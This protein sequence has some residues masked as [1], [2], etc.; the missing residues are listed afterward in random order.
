MDEEEYYERFDT[1]AGDPAELF[2]H[3]ERR[4]E[5]GWTY[6]A[7]SDS[8][9]GVERG[10]VILPEPGV[11]VRGYPS[12]PR[13]L[14]LETGIPSFFDDETTVAVEEKLNGFNVRIVDAGE[15]LAFTRSGYLCPYTTARAR[16]LLDPAEFFADHPEAM[17]CAELVGP[18]TPYT[19]HEYSDVDSHAVRVFGIR[20]RETGEPLPVRERRE[21]CRAYGFEQPQFFG[22]GRPADGIETVRD[23][24]ADLDVADREGVVM[25]S[26]DGES[27][28][29]YTTES[30]HHLEL[31][32]AFSLPFE[33]GRDF[34]FSRIV[35]DAFQAAEH[36]E[37]R[38]RLR[39][40]AQDLGE[41]ILLPMVE[42]IERVEAGETIGE[43]HTVRGDAEHI[44]ALIDHFE[45]LGLTLEI[46]DDRREAGE[47]VVEFY[48]VSESTRDR[49][50]YYLD[51]GIRD[52]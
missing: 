16:E 52:E 3:F 24:I 8:R 1:T 27:M 34:L 43:H 38:E 47:R 15:I 29:K 36:D 40:R 26:A 46:E 13:I 48:K 20:D 22:Q 31:A 28:V 41:S 9:H 17:L 7:L 37:D 14:V 11:I 18:E 50:Q 25:K 51:G 23:A 2:E 19:S 4:S 21:R 6:H 32:H 5:A 12:V 45:D 30:Q 39:N 35:R 10:T 33:Y 42:T 44:D 49:T